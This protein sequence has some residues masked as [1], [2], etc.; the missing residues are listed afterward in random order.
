MEKSNDTDIRIAS[1]TA[2]QG[3]DVPMIGTKLVSL[4]DNFTKDIGNVTYSLL[5]SRLSWTEKLLAAVDSGKVP[6][7]GLVINE[8]ASSAVPVSAFSDPWFERR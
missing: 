7:F 2:L 6:E 8:T 1:L 4:T 5:A 3:Y